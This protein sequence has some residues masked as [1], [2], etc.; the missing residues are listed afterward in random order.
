MR[1]FL[2]GGNQGT[3]YKTNS[4]N[5]KKNGAEMQLYIAGIQGSRKGFVVDASISRGRMALEKWGGL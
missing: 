1:I 5:L 4:S 2:A 3:G